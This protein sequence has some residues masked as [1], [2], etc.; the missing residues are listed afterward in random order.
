V[1][2]CKIV[3]P[4]GID[5][6]RFISK[7]VRAT[8]TTDKKINQ[9]FLEKLIEKTIKKTIVSYQAYE[10]KAVKNYFQQTEKRLY[11]YPELTDNIEKYN[12][13]I[14]DLKKEKVSGKSKD[15]LRMSASGVR[16]DPDDIQEGKI[17]TIE[18]K[19]EKDQAEID[20]INRALDNIKDDDYYMIVEYKYFE[21]RP[22]VEIGELIGC[23][24]RTVRRHKNRLVHRLS[25]KLYG[26]IVNEQ[27]SI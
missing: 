11:T 23:N 15:I 26:A 10:K 7:V 27:L 19:I 20:V 17:L 12:L 24:E 13:D 22:D 3:I 25:V 18:Q 1:D 16:L 21:G 6:E 2:K 8:I 9:D 14:M 5:L 4:D